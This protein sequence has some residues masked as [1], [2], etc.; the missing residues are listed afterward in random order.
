MRAHYCFRHLASVAEYLEAL[1]GDAAPFALPGT[2]RVY[3]ADRP[4]VVRHLHLEAEIAPT[5]QTAE[6]NVTLSLMPVVDVATTVRLDAQDLIIKDI[7]FQGVP[8]PIEYEYDGRYL[9][10]PLPEA[11]E[12]NN[13]FHL[14]V[15]F[16]VEKPRLGLYFVQPTEAEPDRPLQ[17][18][19]QNQDDDARYWFPCMDHP[20]MKMTTSVHISVPRE[21]TVLSNGTPDPLEP[22]DHYK[23]GW[24][25]FGY[26][27][28][29]PQPIYLLSVVVGPFVEH[30]EPG[31]G[32][33]LRWWVLPGHEE[34]GK[35]TFHRTRA[36]VE[37]FNDFIGVPYAWDRYGQ[38]AVSEF[39]FGG[40]E[41]T[42]LTTVTDLVLLDERAS[43]DYSAD[44]LVAHELAH[45]W[46]G[47]LV[48][49]R[50]WSHGWLN[51]GFA[52]YF[53]KLFVQHDKGQD[54]FDYEM[55]ELAE[56]YFGESDGKYARPIVTREYAEPID[57]F[58]RHLYFKGA[59]VLHMLRAKLGEIPFRRALYNYVSRFAFNQAETHDLV[60]AAEDA[61][62]RSLA[63]FFDEWVHAPGYPNL[64]VETR[65]E[66][67]A[68][69]L[70]VE[71]SGS[72]SWQI[73]STLLLRFGDEE[74][75]VPLKLHRQ[76]QT[77]VV[78]LAKRPD[79]AVVDPDF[80]L[81]AKLKL[82]MSTGLLIAQLNGAPS[83]ARRIAAAQTLAKKQATTAFK[84]LV[85]AL[86]ADPFWG[87]RKAVALALGKI[88]TPAA[89]SALIA[90]L[91]RD[92]HPKARRGIITA[93]GQFKGSIAAQDALEAPA[94]TG[95][96]TYLVEAEA[97]RSL[98]RIQ[99]PKSEPICIAALGRDSFMEVVRAAALAGLGRFH[100]GRA[101]DLLRDHCGPAHKTLVRTSAIMALGRV[102][103]D[104]ADFRPAI[105]DHLQT[106]LPEPNL[107]IQIALIQALETVAQPEVVS[108]LHHMSEHGIDG[109]VIRRAREA[110]MGLAR[111][112]DKTA[113]YGSLRG[114]LEDL[115]AENRALRAR[116]DKLDQ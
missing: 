62:G 76:R 91:G 113:P 32:P 115:R 100:T 108:T 24:H 50:D 87:V 73:D 106:L 35:R 107:R 54:E 88:G 7:Y 74:R 103:R 105:L 5:A 81:L 112:A 92:Q 28:E 114:D 11:Q 12:L 36:M 110:Q 49:C 29:T 55:M 98:G 68:L 27:L 96:E 72:G 30:Q 83:V 95:A 71:Q 51:E 46:F 82:D 78:P 93:L 65:W 8:E 85:A 45:Q 37:F 101:N 9:D 41:N 67:G 109:R 43:R 58:D 86:G 33:E 48:T 60:R 23:E 80:Q 2:G 3:P 97:V 52:T 42:T 14:L 19:S 69:T 84:A 66:D 17:V 64:S 31:D 26:K 75:R 21:F 77:I 61:T 1:R 90:A 111:A 116:V 22:F 104:V 70:A 4:V 16:K 53:D 47:D 6:G 15:G 94:T 89:E 38:V 79:M 99:T 44:G 102:A 34:D 63:R 20:G 13:V 10:I 39:V 25:S 57:I 18:W 59:W 56:G 40:M